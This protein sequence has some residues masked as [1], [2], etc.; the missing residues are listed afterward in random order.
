MIP[1]VTCSSLSRKPPC[2]Y[3]TDPFRSEWAS[4]T[5]GWAS[6]RRRLRVRDHTRMAVGRYAPSRPYDSARPAF[7]PPKPPLLPWSSPAAETFP[8]AQTATARAPSV[9]ADA[10]A[11]GKMRVA[12]AYGELASCAGRFAAA[13]ASYARAGV[14]FSVR[15]CVAAMAL[16]VSKTPHPNEFSSPKFCGAMRVS[17]IPPSMHMLLSFTRPSQQFTRGESCQGP[18]FALWIP[19]LFMKRVQSNDQLSLFCPRK[20]PGLSDC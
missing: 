10:V 16:W 20:S 15:P 9:D 1:Y 8:H 6:D 3:F 4:F 11:W 18:F 14:T 17:I 5:G 13:M 7:S 19:N 2:L 12:T